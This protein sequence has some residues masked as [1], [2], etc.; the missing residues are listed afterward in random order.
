MKFCPKCKK[1]NLL[2]TFQMRKKEKMVY[3]VIVKNV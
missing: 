3:L 2:N 1:T